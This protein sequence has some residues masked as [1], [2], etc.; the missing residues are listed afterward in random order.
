MFSVAVAHRQQTAFRT[1][2][3]FA[4]AQRDACGGLV[5]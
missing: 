5:S 4:A 1:N 2:R 3:Q